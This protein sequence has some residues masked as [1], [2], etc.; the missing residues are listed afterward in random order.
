MSVEFL[1]SERLP[2]DLLCQLLSNWRLQYS[3]RFIA[4]RHWG[5][6]IY[7]SLPTRWSSSSPNITEDSTL[8]SSRHRPRGFSSQQIMAA[9]LAAAV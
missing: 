9:A 8:K 2:E 4:S 6:K 5:L 7:R 1:G 3:L